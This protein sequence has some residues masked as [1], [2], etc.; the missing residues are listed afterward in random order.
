[1]TAAR[2]RELALATP[3]RV[4]ATIED[5]DELTAWTVI[6]DKDGDL[7]CKMHDGTWVEVS[8]SEQESEDI[9]DYRPFKVHSEVGPAPATNESLIAASRRV[10]EAYNTSMGT[11]HDAILSLH[12]ELSTLEE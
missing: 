7:W 2:D 3:G 8:A 1:M 12:A 6:S 9:F 4:L 11:L 5:M 10:V